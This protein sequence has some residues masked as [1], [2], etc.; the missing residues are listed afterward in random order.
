MPP[1]SPR[2]D[3]FSHPEPIEPSQFSHKITI[4]RH[5]A[6]VAS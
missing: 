5:T 3:A 4:V 1:S 2:V 6:L